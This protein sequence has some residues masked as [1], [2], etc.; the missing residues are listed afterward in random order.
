[1]QLKF[2]FFKGIVIEYNISKKTRFCCVYEE[3]LLWP[4]SKNAFL[5][6]ALQSWQVVSLYH[7]M[8]NCFIVLHQSAGLFVSF[9]IILCLF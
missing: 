7:K 5:K 2:R 6:Y 1:M 4:H 9:L 8:H 3:N